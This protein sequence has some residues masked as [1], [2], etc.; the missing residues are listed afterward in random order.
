MLRSYPLIASPTISSAAPSPYIGAV[1]IIFTPP[2]N[3]VLI[4]AMD[5]FLSTSPKLP[6]AEFSPP[7]AQVPTATEEISKLLL[8]NFLY[9]ISALL[10]LKSTQFV[11]LLIDKVRNRSPY[12]NHKLLPIIHQLNVR[13]FPADILVRK[14]SLLRYTLVKYFSLNII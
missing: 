1:S 3:I 6:P 13:P 11:F 7:I 4:A 12:L 5:S 8:P 14:P 2:S 9:L 10:L